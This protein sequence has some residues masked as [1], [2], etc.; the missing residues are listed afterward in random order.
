[1]RR[2]LLCSLLAVS[3]AVAAGPDDLLSALKREDL[4]L[5]LRKN[6]ADASQLRTSWINPVMISYTDNRNEQFD[7]TQVRRDFTVTV[8]QPIFKSGGIWAAIKYAA[9]TQAVGDLAVERQRRAMVKTV[10]ATLFNFKKNRYQV[11]KQ[12]LLIAN[13]RIDILR[14]KEQFL[15]GDLDS[16]FLDQAILKKNRDTL[17]LYALQDAAAQ[18][19]KQFKD[20]SDADPASVLLPHFTLIDRRDFL[21][22][23]ID[24]AQSRQAVAQKEHYNTMT[25]SRYLPTLSVQASYI[26]PI[27]NNYLFYAGSY[28]GVTDAY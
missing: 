4:A 22:H 26:K 5:Q 18:L 21:A 3:V 9:S 11:Q 23:H 25:W 10:V 24:L 14:K 12:Q 13:D 20:Y 16:G 8:D 19:R 1:M 6:A 17:Q 2:W 27:E 15:S 28:P 7:T